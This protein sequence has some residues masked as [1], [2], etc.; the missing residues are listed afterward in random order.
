[1]LLLTNKFRSYVAE[2]WPLDP[3]PPGAQLKTTYHKI[4][5]KSNDTTKEVAEGVAATNGSSAS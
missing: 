1:M 4:M 5:Q 2:T 3:R